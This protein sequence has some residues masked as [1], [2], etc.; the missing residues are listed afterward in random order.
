M[1]E[2]AALEIIDRLDD[3]RRAV[4]RL[5]D[6]S[7]TLA[8]LDDEG[9]ARPLFAPTTLGRLMIF[10]HHAAAGSPSALTHPKAILFL[11]T[12]ALACAAAF[13]HANAEA[14]T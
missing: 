8:D 7:L 5:D 9:Q 11:A 6:G 3:G 13:D 2:A 10:A 1:S 12:A 4:V 14:V